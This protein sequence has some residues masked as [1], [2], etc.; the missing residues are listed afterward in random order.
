V[1]KW[2]IKGYEGLNKIYEHEIPGYS[3]GEV[4]VLLQ[5]LVCQSLSYEEITSA[6]LRK[7]SKLRVGHL[8]RIGTGE[9]ITVGENPMY[10]AERV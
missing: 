9:P 7:S 1:A 10:L 4:L 8:D 5:R 6:S 3:E 2:L